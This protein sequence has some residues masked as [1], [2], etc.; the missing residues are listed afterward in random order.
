[1]N[2]GFERLYEIVERLRDPETGCPWDLKQTSKS[3]IPNFIEELYETIEAIEHEDGVHLSE[4]LGDL[5]LH[6]VLQIKIAAEQGL[7]EAHEV[8]DKIC[9]KL[10]L[11]HPH[12]F[13]DTTAKDAETVKQN[14]EKIKLEEKRHE[15][16]SILEG[17]PEAMPALIV[18]QRTQDKASSIGFDWPTID[19]IFEKLIE[20]T[21][22]LKEAIKNDHAENI[23]E[24]IGD[25][26]FT[27]VNLSRKLGFDAETALRASSK[28]FTNRF[29]KVEEHYKKNHLDMGNSSLE[30]LD[31]VWDAVKQT[32]R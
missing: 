28:K 17:I 16:Q 10:I 5:L 20:E 9:D 18:A 31:E 15:R 2:Q 1:M 21:D 4:E 13:S 29:K 25:L 3:L 19:P 24:E 8:F 26:L 7:F 14:W 11:R 23:E 27:I 22:E 12:I 30:E 6:I 32:I